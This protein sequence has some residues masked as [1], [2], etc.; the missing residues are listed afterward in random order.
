MNSILHDGFFHQHDHHHHDDHHDQHQE[1]NLL[2]PPKVCL[3][4]MS[5]SDPHLDIPHLLVSQDEAHPSLNKIMS[6]LQ[7]VHEGLKTPVSSHPNLQS[8]RRENEFQDKNVSSAALL[9]QESLHQPPLR[10]SSSAIDWNGAVVEATRKTSRQF[11]WQTALFDNSRKTSFS[12]LQPFSQAQQGGL[13]M[14]NLDNKQQGMSVATATMP[15]QQNNFA[16][17]LS[18]SSSTASAPAPTSAPVTTPAPGSRG[19]ALFGGVFHRGFFSK[20]VERTEEE[21]YRYLMA[22]DR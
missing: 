13:V 10:K 16:Q 5:K 3:R 22:L 7:H 12:N 2:Q 21:N 14:S 4:T 17:T 19:A 15:Q 8:L 9:S 1:I 11:D 18:Q 6:N 20:P